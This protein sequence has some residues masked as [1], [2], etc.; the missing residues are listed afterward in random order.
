[1]NFML[2]LAKKRDSVLELERRASYAAGARKILLEVF[3]SAFDRHGTPH[4]FEA[5]HDPIDGED[6]F[7]VQP[8]RNATGFT[9]NVGRNIR[10]SGGEAYRDLRGGN[11]DVEKARAEIDTHIKKIARQHGIDMSYGA[12][13]HI[14]HMLTTLVSRKL[15]PVMIT[16][17]IKGNWSFVFL[18][19]GEFVRVDV[20]KPAVMEQLLAS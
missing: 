7:T 13:G 8:R 1:M 3:A 2:N 16:G 4:H 11:F 17:G 10:P 20:E 19:K 9:I 12:G 14:F 15:D 5:R 6:R 18:I